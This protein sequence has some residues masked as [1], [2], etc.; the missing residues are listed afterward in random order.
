MATDAFTVS[1]LR[2]RAAE[3]RA[4]ADEIDAFADT[5]ER[6]MPLIGGENAASSQPVANAAI[7]TVAPARSHGTGSKGKPAGTMGI[8]WRKR[9][10]RI[11]EVADREPFDIDIVS[12]VYTDDTGTAAKPS[13]LKRQFD[14]FATHGYVEQG[15]AGSYTLTDKLRRLIQAMDDG[16]SALR[17]ENGAETPASDDQDEEASDP[18]APAHQ[19]LTYD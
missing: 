2:A 7:L 4:R 15:P 11:A 3:L 14:S 5:A 13:A 9:F 1:T 8:K 18:L 10:A 6:L 19:S 17:N 12:D 16:A